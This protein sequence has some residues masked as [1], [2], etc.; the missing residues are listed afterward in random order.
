MN[1]KILIAVVLMLSFA[2]GIDSDLVDSAVAKM[3]RDGY[4]SVDVEWSTICDEQWVVVEYGWDKYMTKKFPW[5]VSET[6]IEEGKYWAKVKAFGGISAI[7]DENG[8][9][10]T[11]TWS[12]WKD[13]D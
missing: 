10:H 7:I 12:E 11:F 1:Y 6:S 3:K 9:E 8:K 5:G 4:Q 2:P 13:L